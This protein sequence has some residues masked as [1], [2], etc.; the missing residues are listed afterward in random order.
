MQYIFSTVIDGVELKRGS[1]IGCID[2]Y[3]F[4][5]EIV[6]IPTQ[7]AFEVIMLGDSFARNGRSILQY[8]GDFWT[9]DGKQIDDV[10][11][12]GINKGVAEQYNLKVDKCGFLMCA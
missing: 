12:H 4:P 3:I 10:V 5:M 11:L 1:R 8:W 2:K 6:R 9:L 7:Y